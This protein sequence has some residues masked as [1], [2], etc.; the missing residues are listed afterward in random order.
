MAEINESYSIKA[1]PTKELFIYM[2]TRD[3]PLIRAILDL[4]DN[5]VDGAT[6]TQSDDDYSKFWIRI[7]CSKDHFSISDNCGGITVSLARDYAFRFGRPKEMELTP[8]SIGKFGVG[9][10]RS[11][12]KL[13][14]I[15]KV[16]STTSTS[17]FIVEHD[18]KEWLEKP[19]DWH[20][21]FK[22]KDETLDNVPKNKIG[23]KILV[24]ELL[25]NVSKN[26][27]LENFRNELCEELETAHAV[28]M[29][30]GLAI[31]FNGR[32]LGK[33]TLSLLKSDQLQPAFIEKRYEN[34]GESVVNVKIYA[35]IADRDLEKGGWYI[36]CNGRM[37]L[38]ADQTDITTWGG[39]N[40]TPKYHPDF[41]FFRGYVFFDSDD[42]ELLPWTTT[43]TG[44]DSDSNLYKAVN[45]EMIT[46]MRPVLDFLRKLANER[47]LVE[48]GEIEISPLE[49]AYKVTKP[50][51]Y[52]DVQ[53][54][55]HFIIPKVTP[56]PR[57]PRL[58][59]IQYNKP[60]DDIKMVK[61]VLRVTTYKAVGEKTF[62]YFMKMEC[63]E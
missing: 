26:F 14:N 53:Q 13:G 9:M 22:E 58:G 62:D 40:P 11:F 29:A 60:L 46:L 35:G 7:E 32:P 17:K 20:F 45:L 24:T 50:T 61:K 43:K 25:N 23:T 4:V 31:S 38:E 57:R 12:F 47:A 48:R 56:L 6:R 51:N 18:V 8:G 55:D 15:F 63:E 10:K 54:Q 21:K 37:V 52:L 5:S 44:V 3:I 39:S 41:A 30:K 34:L 16:E 28:T 27:E 1:S 42:A 33:R 2:L 19:E 59:R 49:E 36:F